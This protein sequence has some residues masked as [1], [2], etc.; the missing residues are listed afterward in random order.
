M[1]SSAHR[2]MRDSRLET[3]RDRGRGRS[4]L[5]LCQEAAASSV[6]RR[7]LAASLCQPS[8][9][10]SA[11]PSARPFLNSVCAEPSERASFGNLGSPE[12]HDRDHDDDDDPIDSEDL[13]EHAPGYSLAEK[14][15]PELRKV[16]GTRPPA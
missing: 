13:G 3:L 11:A 12:E 6:C 7:P 14:G 9:L 1:T 8:L 4:D 5:V 2:L 15:S 10:P 16:S